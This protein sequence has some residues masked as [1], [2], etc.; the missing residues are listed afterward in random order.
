[1]L[2][3][4]LIQNIEKQKV[5]FL[6]FQFTAIDGSLKQLIHPARNIEDLLENGL[7]F[8][9]SSCKYVPVNQ[10]DLCLKPDL[11]TYQTLPWGQSEN[12][13]ARFICDVYS[14][15]GSTPFQSDPRG[16]LK[17]CI[18]AMKDE[19]GSGWDLVC[20]PEIEFFLLEKDENGVFSPHDRAT[21][22]DIPPYDAGTE[23]RKDMS[24]LLDSLGIT[25]EKNH[26]EVPPG[27]HEITFSHDTALVTADNTMT[28]RQAVKYLA[29]Q[30]SLVASFMPKP[31]AW[32]YGCGMHVHVNL[33]D[34]LTGKN[35][36]FDPDKKDNVSDIALHFIAGLLDHA[37]GL[38]GI[39]NPSINSYKRL[40]PGWEAPVYVSWGFNNRS[41]LLRIPAGNPRAMRLETRNPDSSCNPYLAF[42]AILFAGLD[43]IRRKLD[44]PAA[45]N[46][47]IYRMT[48]DERKA[49]GIKDLPGDLKEA[50]IE[51]EQ[52][53]VLEKA[54]GK[55]FLKTFLDI[56]RKEV[57]EFSTTIHSWELERYVH[58]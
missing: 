21:Y 20:A 16:L 24:R 26:H 32:T 47:D 3:K 41:S 51:L 8:D 33:K 49:R 38:T 7:G 40:V 57:Q 15:D 17:K 37:R 30:R 27:K 50:L 56:K 12:R 42:A 23:F 25:T 52:D 31:F 45:I 53:D 58:V 34:S 43:G 46:D 6:N 18:A 1:V 36:F 5:S 9:G 2:I 14:G 28:Y 54:F 29:G 35:L 10:S 39:T 44:P 19:F 48:V 4:D 22:F 11:S 55:I 13:T